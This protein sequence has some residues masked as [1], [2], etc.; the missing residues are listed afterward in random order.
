[1]NINGHK[2]EDKKVNMNLSILTIDGKAQL[3]VVLHREKVVTSG[4]AWDETERDLIKA[5]FPNLECKESF[6]SGATIWKF[7]GETDC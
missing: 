4:I 7:R 1:M 2:V 3:E 6:S 5:T